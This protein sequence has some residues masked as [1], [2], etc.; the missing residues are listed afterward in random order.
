M[1][2]TQTYINPAFPSSVASNQ[3]PPPGVR[4]ELFTRTA[5]TSIWTV[6]IGVYYAKVTVV[7]GSG[8]SANP[9][10]GNTVTFDTVATA[11]GGTNSDTCGCTSTLG[12]FSVSTTRLTQQVGV[13]YSSSG[14]ANYIT[15]YGNNS[16]P[17]SAGG[18][19][20]VYLE[21]LVPGTMFRITI[22]AAITGGVAG[23][24]LVEY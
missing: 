12:A 23:C 15:S 4:A 24:V 11:T 19:G 20:I 7:G 13:N 8:G 10:T 2:G 17:N 9:S 6:P 5:A 3:T 18:Q 22:G 14:T 16:N 21:N 1:A